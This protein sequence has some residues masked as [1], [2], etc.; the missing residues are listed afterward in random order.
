MKTWKVSILIIGLLLICVSFC[1]AAKKKSK[2]KDDKSVK[3]AEPVKLDRTVGDLAEIV[4]LR[5]INVKGIGLVVGLGGTGSSECPPD[6]RDYLRKY[7]MTQVGRKDLINPD[8]MIN[9][10]DTAVVTVEG[11]IPAAASKYEAFDIT[12]K[13]LPGTQTTSLAG[14]RLYTTDLKFVTR[15]E[16][17]L[18]SSRTL[19]YAA[20]P[21]YTDNMP[22]SKTSPTNGL[23]LGGGKVIE[24]YQITLAL[25][26]PDF[27]AAAYIRN[28]INQRFGKDVANAVSES[29]INV[30]VPQFYQ[31]KKSRFIMLVKSLYIA[32][33]ASLEEQRINQLVDELK[34]VSDKSK[35]QVSLL[36]IG[37]PTIDKLLPLLDSNDIEIKFTVASNFIALGDDRGLKV[38]RD[39][40]QNTDSPL[41]MQAIVNIG[42]FASKNNAV[43]LMNRLVGD[44]N[45]D[46]RYTAYSYLR[47]HNDASILR[48]IIAEDFFIDQIIT[49]GPKIIFASRKQEP[50]IVLFG[51]PVDCEKGIYI[52]SEDG[53][54]IINSEPTD[55]RVSILRKHPLTGGLMGPLKCSTRIADIIKLLGDPP[56]PK[57]DKKRPGLGVPYSEI[58]MMLKNM[59][60]KGAVN[61]SFVPGP[62]SQ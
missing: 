30:I 23:I 2:S 18:E 22:D 6:M 9:S 39:F 32:S 31:N 58:V 56:S 51:A 1:E 27:K 29:V 38:M 17:T 16:E 36:A 3:D 4:S 26:K 47:M 12:V 62:V 61:A 13:P 45:F 37:K 41:R 42:E 10:I 44:S 60:D 14:G 35:P 57:D 59:V 21:I 53:N 28:R 24:D 54:I 33:N 15:V 40:A 5:P 52:E 55:E 8:V 46:V 43:A 50:G 49:P 48:S 34:T 7:I 20:G 11:V 19:A 25:Y